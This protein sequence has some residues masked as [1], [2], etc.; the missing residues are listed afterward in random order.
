MEQSRAEAVLAAALRLF[1]ERGYEATSV[2]QIA[3]A[4]GVGV[5]TIYRYFAA[6]EVLVN[7]LFRTWKGQLLAA[8]RGA[9][10]GDGGVRARFDAIWAALVEFQRANP[11]AFAFL[12]MHYHGAYL[13]DASQAV[14]A[15]VNQLVAEFVAAG[16]GE[17]KPLPAPVLAAIVFGAFVGLVK[18][19]EAGEIRLDEGTLAAAGA[20]AWAAIAANGR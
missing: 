13:D 18:A 10:A 16:A 7:E 6:K 14:V 11:A 17:L 12:E 19:A 3:T 20:C 5:G 9:L 15:E 8:L 2:P 1:T 4:A